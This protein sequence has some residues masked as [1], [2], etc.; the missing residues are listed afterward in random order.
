MQKGFSSKILDRIIIIGIILTI[1]TL[2]FLPLGITAM[3]KSGFGITR[4]N[5]PMIISISVYICAI[6]YVFALFLLKKLCGLVSKKDSFSI[7]T[8]VYLKKIA[9]CSFSEIFIFNAVQIGLYY[10]FDIYLYV[11]TVILVV[12]VSFISLAIGFLSLVLSKLFEI[13]IEIKDENDKTI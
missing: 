8:P 4:S 13:A 1:A 5:I 11:I 7:K 6:P 3:V 2:L 10:L 9:I 12:V